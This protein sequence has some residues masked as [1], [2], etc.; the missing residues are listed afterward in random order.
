MSN[1]IQRQT[2]LSAH[3]VGFSRFLRAKGFAVG[4]DREADALRAMARVQLGDDN[5]FY[6][7]L[8]AV[9]PQNHKQVREFDHHD[10]TEFVDRCSKS[11][12]PILQR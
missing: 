7:A 4:P 11:F 6:L 8:R 12:V 1:L 10:T 2:E 5:Q 9:Y 3:V